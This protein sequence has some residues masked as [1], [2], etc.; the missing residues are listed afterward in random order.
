MDRLKTPARS[1]SRQTLY[2][3]LYREAQSQLDLSST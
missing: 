2:F 3:M 1:G